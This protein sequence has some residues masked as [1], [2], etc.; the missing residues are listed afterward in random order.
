M[1][2]NL[3]R[4][5]LQQS[6]LDCFTE[7]LQHANRAA[8]TCF[9]HFRRLRRLKRRV[10]LDVGN[11]LAV[12]VI[13]ARDWTVVSQWS[14]LQRVKI[15]PAG[16]VLAVSL[17]DQVSP[18][19]MKLPVRYHIQFKPAP[20]DG[21]CPARRP[22]SI[23]QSRPG[24]N[25]SDF[26]LSPTIDRWYCRIRY[27]TDADRTFCLKLY[28]RLSENDSLR[29]D[30]QCHLYHAVSRHFG[31]V[32]LWLFTVLSWLFSIC[33]NGPLSV[34][35]LTLANFTTRQCGGVMFSVSK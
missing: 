14:P 35:Q 34:V 31:S 33:D 25:Q 23:H 22:V 6:A 12:A 8:S 1:T 5:S 27:T 18:A 4:L 28:P 20:A 15:A 30:F 29:C 7:A 11:H 32:F 24:T 16:R 9:F 19:L 10:A 3:A 26:V 13:F 21:Y 17:H 2:I